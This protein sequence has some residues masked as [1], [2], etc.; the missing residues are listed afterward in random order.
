M[1]SAERN[2]YGYLPATRYSLRRDGVVVFEGSEGECWS[3]LQEMHSY[4]VHHAL[5]H[6]GYEMVP[7]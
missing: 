5:K 7:A 1:A 3:Y 4:S 2:I 6:E